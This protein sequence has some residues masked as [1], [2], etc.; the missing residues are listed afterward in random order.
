MF[1]ANGVAQWLQPSIF[2]SIIKMRKLP[3]L[4]KMPSINT[5]AYDIYVEDFMVWDVKFIWY[6]ITYD[7]LKQILTNNKK[8][9]TF[10]IVDSSGM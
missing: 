3:Y 2:D 7:K 6:G 5:K 9:Q 1:I 4:P 8:I 10:P